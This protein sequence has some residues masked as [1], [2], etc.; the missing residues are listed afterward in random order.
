[1][2]HLKTFTISGACGPDEQ[3]FGIWLRL[4]LDWIKSRRTH[5]A[6][7]ALHANLSLTIP[8]A[9]SGK[10]VASIRASRARNEGRIAIVTD[11]GRG[12]R[13]T[14]WAAQDERG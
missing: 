10:S 3:E 1:V 2:I 6:P 8:L 11:V 7:F 9:P 14:L 12:M 5:S 4:Q 13:W